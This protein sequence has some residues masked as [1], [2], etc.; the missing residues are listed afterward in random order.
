MDSQGNSLQGKIAVVTG[1]GN[2][3]GEGY[4]HGLAGRGCKVVVAEIDA[5]NGQR[6]A[7][8]IN[9]GGGEALF[10]QADVSSEASAGELASATAEKWG[11]IDYLV[12]NAALF[13]DIEFNSL[14]AVDL[15]YLNK[16]ISINM[17]GALVMA[18]AIVPHMPSGSAIVN[19]TSTAAWMHT[20]YYSLTKLGL[21]GITTILARELGP[22]GI[23]V[24][25]IAPG[26]TDTAALR[27]KVPDDYIKGMVAQMPISR[28]GTPEDLFKGVAFLL[29]DEAQWITG[30]IM[31]VDGGQLLR[32]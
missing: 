23:R 26:P 8:A 14:M 32:V 27:S 21:N 1:A 30:H 18:R 6:V 11:R 3:I 7:D 12:N 25:A 28:L 29:S 16:V 19:Q 5:A 20:D 2:G 24:N 31:N 17:L 10:L 4:A 9:A 22:K 15:A 13:G